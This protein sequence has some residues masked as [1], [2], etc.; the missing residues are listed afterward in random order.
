[1]GGQEKD[2]VVEGWPGTR[3]GRERRDTLRA[4]LVEALAKVDE[5]LAGDQAA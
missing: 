3:M 5:E 1:M 4:A 2:T